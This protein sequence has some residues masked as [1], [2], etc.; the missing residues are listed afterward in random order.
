MSNVSKC[1]TYI[2]SF[3]FVGL[4]KGVKNSIRVP[5]LFGPVFDLK[6]FKIVVSSARKETLLSSQ[7]KDNFVRVSDLAVTTAQ[8]RAE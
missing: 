8:S 4:D 1:T 3:L 7:M 6:H 2:C 5:I